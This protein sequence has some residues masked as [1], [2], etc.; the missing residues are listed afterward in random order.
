MKLW[1]L[2]A[3][4]YHQSNSNVCVHGMGSGAT[5]VQVCI[6]SAQVL[7]DQHPARFLSPISGQGAHLRRQPLALLTPCS[8]M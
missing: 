3:C 2:R 7:P 4:L 1:F 5:C 8:F 6:H